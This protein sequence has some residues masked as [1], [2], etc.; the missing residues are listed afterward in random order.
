MELEN[1]TAL[2]TGAKRGIGRAIAIC[3]AE[4]GAD[5][6]IFDL[7]IENNDEVI[8]K[9]RTMGRKAYAYKVNITDNNQIVNSV[10]KAVEECGKIDIL[11]NNAGIYPSEFLLSIKEAD[12]DKVMDLNVKALFF[13]AQA[14]ANKSMVP[15]RSGKIINI[16]SSDGKVPSRGI[17]HYAASKAAVISITKSF[18]LELSEFNIRSNCVAPG[19]V[20]T[21]TLMKSDRWKSIIKNIPSGRLGEMSEVGE[22]VAFLVSDAAAYINGEVL[23][24]NG[25]IYMD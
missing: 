24:V 20:A 21:E 2:I 11:V 23:D 1:Q 4:K 17:A 19:W 14:V 25:G 5:I 3:L 22:A 12:W 9:I 8:I 6:I 16:A 18:T 7:D 15:N 10:Q 13:V